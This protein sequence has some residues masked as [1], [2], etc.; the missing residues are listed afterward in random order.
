[1]NYVKLAWVAA[2]LRGTGA[3]FRIRLHKAVF[4]LQ[5]LGFPTSYEFDLYIRGPY[6]SELEGDYEYLVESGLLHEYA[7]YAEVDGERWGPIVDKLNAEDTLVLEV[8]ATLY[9]LLDAGWSLE[10]AK[11]R[12]LELKPY[13]TRR[14]VEEGVR[15][16]RELGL[17]SAEGAARQG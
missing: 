6:S 4:L 5:A 2:R 1:V 16:L 8:A 13:A 15:L 17:L 9:D 3:A 14:L 11:R 7:K 12:V 10:K